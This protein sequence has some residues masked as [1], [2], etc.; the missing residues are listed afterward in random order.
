[1]HSVIVAAYN[2]LIMIL[3]K[4]PS[5]L[6]DKNCLQ[7]VNNCIEIG[8]SGSSSLRDD[9][10]DSS[11]A[12]MKADKELKPAS[13]RVKEAAECVLCF[14][15]EHMSMAASLGLVDNS[16]LTRIALNEKNLLELT[17][18]NNLGKFKYFAIDGSLIIAVF[19]KP[20]TKSVNTT[21]NSCP[22]L[23]L[24]LRGPFTCQAWS[25]HLRNSP[26]GKRSSEANKDIKTNS[27]AEN[28]LN[29]SGL[30]QKVNLMKQENSM[31]RKLDVPVEAVAKAVPKCEHSI[32]S[33]GDV[34]LKC[35]K[36]LSKFEQFKE[37][38]IKFELAAVDRVA[39]E[40]S[41]IS[42]QLVG[43]GAASV[44]GAHDFQ[45]ARMLLSHLGFCSLESSTKTN[46]DDLPEILSIDAA[47]PAFLEQLANL[48]NLPTRTF[49]S[50]SI[51]YI[52]KNQ[53]NAKAIINN[54]SAEADLDESFYAFVQSIGSIID[55]SAASHKTSEPK[56]SLLKKI[57]KINGVENIFYWSDITSEIVF[58]MPS[59][60]ADSINA[61]S[62]DEAFKC[63][64]QSIPNDTKV[65]IIW[66]EQIQ[67]A[68]AVPVDE[69]LQETFSYEN[70]SSQRPKEVI[71]LF[72]HPLKSKMHR[73]ITWNN[74]SKKYFYTM[75]L[76][77][78]MVV[79][80]RMLS[81]M[82]RQTVLN[83]F[84]RKRLEIDDYQPPHVKRK[85]KITEIIKKF[86]AKKSEADYYT[87]LLM[88]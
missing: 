33:L 36:N 51:F 25:L 61:S 49:A 54:I 45:S 1:M 28:L 53:C 70:L 2:C 19:E 64:N 26:L 27:S 75:P 65:M 43:E 38:Q 10:K 44:K 46:K 41:R 86:Q 68:D 74:L 87:S 7:T 20:L 4:K 6:R 62:L 78:G 24:L 55:V 88:E 42:T 16:D 8:I 69:L 71:I 83:I 39:A 37:E 22:T 12:L 79:S 34:A 82:V 3:I 80:S 66:L 5:L 67:D 9:A 63:K 18:K 77:D 85:N 58:F 35:V 40:N 56:E 13:L 73:I 32:P 30:P 29:Q 57:N 76:V 15:M 21:A 48:D 11:G 23:T 84:K 47:E 17:N 60:Q 52:K 81:S 31:F 59:S 14:I 50:C 72:I